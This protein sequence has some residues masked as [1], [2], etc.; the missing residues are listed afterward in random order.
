MAGPAL[1]VCN[2]ASDDSLAWHALASIAQAYSP[3]PPD[4]HQCSEQTHNNRLTS[5]IE[6]HAAPDLILG[7]A[8]ELSAT[9]STYAVPANALSTAEPFRGMSALSRDGPGPATAAASR[10]RAAALP[11]VLPEDINCW[12][13]ASEYRPA[14]QKRVSYA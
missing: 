5:P 2:H 13:E 7:L 10:S 1:P 9:S 11:W 6:L 4:H 3:P 8:L 14:V 12:E